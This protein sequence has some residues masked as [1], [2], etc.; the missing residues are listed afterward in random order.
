MSIP[1]IIHQ[2]WIGYN[3][4][5]TIWTNTFKIDYIQAHPDYEYKLWNNETSYELLS[6]Y[7][8]LQKLYNL[9]QT[10]NGKS[11]ILRYVILSEFG[12]IYIDA[13]SV[14]VNQKSFDDLLNNCD[15]GLFA[16]KEPDTTH[17]TGGVIGSSKGHPIFNKLINHL[18]NYLKLDN[19][20]ITVKKYNR[21]R[22]MHGPS[23][24]LGPILFDKYAQLEKITVFPSHYFYP[25]TWHGITS[26]DVHKTLNIPLD[27][28]MFQ[29]GYSTNHLSNQII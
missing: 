10:W 9:E 1:K 14:W 16:A 21:M 23:T 11:D 26:V 15:C 17:I 12:G 13:D 18:E 19:N 7:P 8:I 4:E 22:A 5:P 20:V 29:Y 25:I 28:Y 3:P 24:L 27:S 2:I 6:K